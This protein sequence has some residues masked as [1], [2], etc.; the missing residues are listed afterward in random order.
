MSAPLAGR[1]V[2]VTRTRARAAG[3][4]DALHELGAAVVMVPLIATEPIATPDAIAKAAAAVAGAPAPRWVVFTSATA[5]RLV[6][7]VLE[8]AALERVEAAAV[9]SETAAA[10]GQAGVTVGVIPSRASAEDLAGE[11]VR[12]GVRGATVWLPVAEGAGNAL[13]DRLRS[14]GAE[15]RVLHLYRS[16]MPPQAPARLAAAL[17]QAP[18]A[19][20]LT[21][22][23]TARHLLDA[24][25]GRPLPAGLAVAC[26]GERTAEAARAAGLRVDIVASEQ[27]GAGLASA[28]AGHFAQRLP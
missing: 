22:G 27:T 16:V 18:D 11:L 28:I 5:V 7:G 3:I 1:R 13:P 12:R 14:A 25:D 2:L 9:G 4:V 20:A 24:L 8:P 17:R 26:I 19:V 15:V 6:L 23:S 10:L 21:S